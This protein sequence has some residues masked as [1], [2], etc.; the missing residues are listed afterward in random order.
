MQDICKKRRKKD[1]RKLRK[2][3]KRRKKRIYC[4]KKNPKRNKT[5]NQRKAVD[6]N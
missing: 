3:Q 4:L 2:R 1:R 6:E 5:A